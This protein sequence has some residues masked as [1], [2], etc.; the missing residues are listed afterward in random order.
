[1][2][3]YAK[4]RNFPLRINKA[5]GI[6][7]IGVT[8]RTTTT[9]AGLKIKHRFVKQTYVTLRHSHTN[10]SEIKSRDAVLPRRGNV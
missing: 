2:N 9:V 5:L 10:K 6:F 4:F 1:M 8:T 3:V 7:R